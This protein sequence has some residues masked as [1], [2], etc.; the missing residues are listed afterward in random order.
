MTTAPENRGGANGGPQY[1]PANVNG[2]GGNGQ[3]GRASGFKYGMN[4]MINDQRTQGNAAVANLARSGANVAPPQL[5][6]VTSIS[7]PSELP[8]QSVMDGASIGDGANSI[9]GLPQPVESDNIEFHNSI[10][11]YSQVLQFVASQPNT[12]KETR[13]I[14][15]FLLR[16]SEIV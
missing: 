16:D 3:S 1:N 13:S 4:K 5:P 8:D 14:I 9:P 15:S 10:R 6:P 12:S 11:Q 7:A 2:N